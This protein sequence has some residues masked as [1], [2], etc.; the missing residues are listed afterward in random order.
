MPTSSNYN[1]LLYK[2]LLVVLEKT[3]HR[4]SNIRQGQIASKYHLIL[5][6]TWW[7]GADLEK[8]VK[9]HQARKFR[10]LQCPQY[11]VFSKKGLPEICKLNCG[12]A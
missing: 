8:V 4:G 7:G 12:F 1:N 5:C 3:G 10:L 6:N 2:Q 11:S 9:C